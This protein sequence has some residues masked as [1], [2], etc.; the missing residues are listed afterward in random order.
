MAKDSFPPRPQFS[1]AAACCD[2]VRAAALRAFDFLV[3]AGFA[4]APRQDKCS[5]VLAAVHFV[6]V[7]RAFMLSYDVRDD[8][9][10]LY[11][12]EVTDGIARNERPPLFG[13]YVTDY[14]MRYHGYRG[15]GARR[16]LAPIAVDEPEARLAAEIQWWADVL[17]GPGRELL[18][19]AP[20]PQ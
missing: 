4:P 12:C 8:I 9:V 3:S 19:D 18:C 1:S 14:L 13:W 10:S 6:G 16:E 2:F 17:R 5:P 20:V 7:H 11:M 15:G